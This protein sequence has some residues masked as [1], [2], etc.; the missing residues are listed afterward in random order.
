MKYLGVNEIREEFLKFFE[1]KDH[2]RLPSFPLVPRND[3]SLLLINSGMA[4][5]KAY[6]TGQEIPPSKRVTTCQ[7]CIRTG[8][9]DNVG[10]TA[11]HGTF[12]E[13][14]GDF[15]F[16]DYF[17]NEIVP[18]SWEFVTKVLEIPEDRLYVTIY[19]EDDETGKIWHD[20]VGLPWDRIVKLGKE[21]NFWEHGTG[22]CGPCTEIYY[23]RGP[24]YGCDSPTCGVGCDCDRYMEFWNLVLTQFNAEE[25]GTYTELAMKNVDTGM[26]LE[27]M[28]T[29][30]Q[31]VDSI[32]DVDTV[33][34]IRDAV[35]AKAGVEYGKDHKTDVSVRVITDHIRSVTMMT[36][37]GVLPSNEGRGYVLRRLLRRAARHGKLLG[38]EGEFLA[39]LSKSVIACSGEAY[40][41]LV[42]KQDYIFKIL[43]IEENS[44]YKTID[45][46]MEILKADM[47]EMKAAG[48]KVMSGEKSFRLYD[49]YGFPVDLTKEILAEE[50]MEID[51]DAFTAEMKAQKERA[52]SARAKSNYMGAAETV[53][54]ELPVELETAFAG[55]DV[56]DVANAKIVALVANEAVA[57]TAQAGDTVAVF[58]DRT[59]F[60]AESGGQ[61]GDQGVIK[62]ETGVVKVTNCVKV[63]GGK[64]AHMG[65]VTEGLVQVGEMACASI[66]V[67]L[68]MA[69]SRN[70]SATHLL[71]KA[72]RTV[73]GTH[74]E[75]AGSYV[76]AERLRFDFTHF[77][78]MTADEIKEVERLVN[79]AI[80]ASYDVHTDEMSIDE[81]RNRGAM[82]LFGEKYGEVVRVVDMGGYSIELCGGAH[83]KN[84]A[85]V[86]SFK[87]LSENGVAAG[88]RR[89]EAVTGKEALKHYQAQE[90]EI[91]EICRLV[92]ST[93]DKLLARLEQLLAEQKETAKE[94]EKLK[95]K[96]AGGAADEML[97]S[98]VEI[99]GV[100]VL[101][102]EV[103]DMDGNALR[104]M[105]DQLKQKLG[106]GVVV[107]ASGKDGKVN[108]MAMATDDVVKKGV[109]AGNIIK[110]AAAVCGGGGGGRPNMAQAGGK[111]A[112]KI[113]DALEKAKA[114]VAEQLG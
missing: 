82:A 44:F 2:L 67:E 98:K 69:S 6:F 88:V 112:S 55:Y 5:M 20:V 46:G 75:Q 48:V 111:D 65:E 43:S 24:E 56:Y 90:D 50:G 96:M 68:R 77:A 36:A 51:E 87:I 8:D 28:A 14:L 32:F 73:L 91:K 108:L 27:R 100:A 113:A 97:N 21:D 86:G 95:A 93:P 13:M 19:E 40:P 76:S 35:C 15:S 81:A 52:R 79:D 53:Y 107:L 23:D 10:K 74:V 39:E 102:A 49:T 78:A 105:G 22:P 70:H 31:G 37:D 72:L 12:F 16:G 29:I 63:V 33:K 34:S 94:L 26:G 47:E 101:A 64:I 62:T 9:I 84:T 66:D 103:K 1:S 71:H 41:E 80:F 4:P 85:Q 104:T 60:Y 99:G 30:M 7:K 58:L 38:I 3:N 25:D 89:I 42:E 83:L 54:N 18:W 114:V 11:R 59:P 61:V 109:H 106:S 57:E 45:K 92:K 17:K 110:A